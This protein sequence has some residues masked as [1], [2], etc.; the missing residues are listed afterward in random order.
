MSS[1]D[2]VICGAGMAG[3]AAAYHLAVRQRVRGIVL[4]DEREPLTLT[5]DKGTQ[6]YRNWFGGP[7]DAMPRFIN[8]SIDILEELSAESG[9][10]FRLGRRGYLFV[11]ASDE[12]R[13]RLHREALDITA[14]GAGPLREHPGAHA[15][16]P[17]PVAGFAGVPT[18]A[19]FITDPALMR[20]EFP[21]LTPDAVA[22]T[23]VRRAGWLD[24]VRLG[25][26]LI[27]QAVAHGAR[28]V[29]DRVE[30][31]EVESA[32]VRTV[33]LASGAR[34]ETRTFV[35][36]AG[37]KLPEVGRMLGLDIPV[38][39]ELHGKMVFQD[40]LG[41]V[42][43]GA[44]MAIWSDPVELPWTKDERRTLSASSDRRWMVERLPGGVH[45]RP[46][47]DEHGTT[48]MLIWTYDSEPRPFE[49]PPRFDPWYAEILLRGV[50]RMVPGLA[51]YFGTGDSGY[52]DGGYYCKTRENRPLI[53][54]LP[55]DG[56]FVI[57]AL[58]G[59]GIMSSHAAGELLAAHVSGATLPG[60]APAFL[61]SRY[62]DPAYRALL[63]SWDA[64][65]GQL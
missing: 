59:Y 50:A 56:A 27:E 1:A 5:S 60:Y 18:G 52:V 64:R 16:V 12:G 43:R 54:P 30:G 44:P 47:D 48:L 45:M 41:V 39:H 3:A 17:S 58:S 7:G 33:R 2:V 8:R 35:V 6:A 46:R 24:A 49:W 21:Y 4:V 40:T 29:R 22:M 65:S 13:E 25:R 57:G 23:H 9:D 62:D 51:A 61:P 32:R 10:T 38:F 20:R 55:V 19:D 63:A 36:A 37:P 31:V 14:L 34:I 15:Y 11:S 42:P 28:V 53:G 26:W